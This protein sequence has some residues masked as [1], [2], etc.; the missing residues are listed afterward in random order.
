VRLPPAGRFS[1]S[2]RFA[3]L[4]VL[5]TAATFLAAGCGEPPSGAEPIAAPHTA[6]VSADAAA[7]AAQHATASLVDATGAP[8]GSVKFT[9]DGTG[10]VHIEVH[11]TGL[12][13]GLHGIHIHAVGACTGPAF[14]SAGSHYNPAARK[15]GLE[16]PQGPHNGDLPN[17]VVN[18][19]GIGHLS[20]KTERVTLSSGPATVFDGDGSAIVIHASEDDQVTDPTGNSG[21]RVACG[22]IVPAED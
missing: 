16:N 5:T 21:S 11:A 19:A 17:L 10:R 22:V 2:I 15:H 3:P 4:V 7:G 14:T 20:A 1:S 6:R 13:P 18:E 12:T 9:Q 8:V